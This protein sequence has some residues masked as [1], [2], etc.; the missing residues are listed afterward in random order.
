MEEVNGFGFDWYILVG[1]PILI[2]L[3]ANSVVPHIVLFGKKMAAKLNIWLKAKRCKVRDEQEA[4]AKGR[5]MHLDIS[6]GHLN[7]STI[8][9]NANLPTARFPR[10]RLSTTL[11]DLTRCLS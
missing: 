10:P 3:L 4:A 1:T 8:A 6:T 7:F 2:T 9:I 11:T 5:K